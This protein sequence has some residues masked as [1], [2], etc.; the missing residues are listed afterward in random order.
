[1]HKTILAVTAFLLSFLTAGFCQTAVSQPS[2]NAIPT[3]ASDS[4]LA[5]AQ[6]VTSEDRQQFQ[7]GM[8][9]VHFDFDRAQLRT[10]DRAVLASN[11]E[12]LK[13]HPDVIVTLEGDA[14]ERGDIVYNLV[15]SG[16]RASATRDA[17]VEL[18]VPS[19]RIAF[20]TGWGKLYPICEQADDSC[21]SQNRRTHF[22]PWPSVPEASQIASR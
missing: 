15:L 1:M 11:A 17:L 12:W 2:N 5:A 13:A 14:D 4:K 21:W 18:G 20:A 9:D 19:D 10:D 6:P 16:Q 22:A 7:Q 3:T 8:K